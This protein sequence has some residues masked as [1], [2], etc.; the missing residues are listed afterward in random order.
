MKNDLDGAIFD[1]VMVN[2]MERIITYRASRESHM[3]DIVFHCSTLI[4]P[5][6]NDIFV[7]FFF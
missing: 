6:G 5:K 4:S 2:F 1:R 7:M 3:P